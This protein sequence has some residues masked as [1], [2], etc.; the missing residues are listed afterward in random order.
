[1]QPSLRGA[2]FLRRL[3]SLGRLLTTNPGPLFSGSWQAAARAKIKHFIEDVSMRNK[4]LAI[5]ITTKDRWDDLAITLDSLRDNGLHRFETIVIDD[6]SN[7][8]MPHA[9]RERFHWVR[10]QRYES[11]Q[12]YIAQRNRLAELLTADLYLSLDDDSYPASGAQLDEAAAW[13]N[14]K[15]DAAA[16]TFAIR[17]SSD[18]TAH[19]LDQRQPYPVR[20]YIG[21]A[22][23]VKRQ[24]FLHLR[25]YT[26][27]LGHYCEETDFALKAW[28]QGFKVYRYP[29][30]AVIHRQSVIGRNNA[31]L[32]RLLT[33]NLIWVS[34]WRSPYVFL[35]IELL[36]RV[37][38]MFRLE[39]HRRHWHAVLHGYFEALAGLPKVA[40][41]RDPVPLRSYLAWLRNPVERT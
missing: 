41:F 28:K 25:G 13:L 5:G 20:Y 15:A 35:I 37:L 9:F 1:M 40:Q 10:F 26:E 31:N 29:S 38:R 8:P 4:T 34:A 30:L 16:L 6:G 23:M 17:T 11:S 7:K 27:A 36:F 2:G 33:R 14:A 12:G 39:A 21:C 32:N 24:L 22:H 18:M 3:A 19:P